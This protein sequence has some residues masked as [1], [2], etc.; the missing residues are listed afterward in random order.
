MTPE[1][2]ALLRAR[3][4]ASGSELLMPGIR[5]ADAFRQKLAGGSGLALGLAESLP[6]V[7][8]AVR[9]GEGLLAGSS[10]IPQ[11]ARE[12]AERRFGEGRFLDEWERLLQDGVRAGRSGG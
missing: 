4:G 3:L 10:L 1:E 6:G 11:T 5:N 12:R 8:T 2:E 7:G 9:A